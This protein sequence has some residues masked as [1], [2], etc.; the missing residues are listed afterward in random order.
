[1]E[2]ITHIIFYKRLYLLL[3][4]NGLKQTQVFQQHHFQ[5]NRL[6]VNFLCLILPYYYYICC[7]P[8]MNS[9]SFLFFTLFIYSRSCYCA[10]KTF[11]EI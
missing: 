5:I 10:K 2:H 11:N 9:F 6:K 1:M 8:F 7:T 3:R 4:V